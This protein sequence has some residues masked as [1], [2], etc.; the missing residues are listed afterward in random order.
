MNR[1]LRGQTVVQFWS[2][3]SLLP[4]GLQIM[5]GP[6]G[7]HWAG[8]VAEREMLVVSLCD[9]SG[10]NPARGVAPWF[11]AFLSTSSREKFGP[12]PA[13]RDRAKAGPGMDQPGRARYNTER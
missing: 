11:N 10:G 5:G 9:L 7:G 2:Q 8:R 1:G 12:A 13:F 4:W 6:E 3:I